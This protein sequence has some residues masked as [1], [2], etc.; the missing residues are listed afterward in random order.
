MT[1]EF[2]T[3]IFS[4]ICGQ[5]NCFII[6]GAA[7][8]VCQRCLGLYVGAALT[9]VWL[10]LSGRWRRGLPTLG[11]ILLHIGPIVVAGLGG[12]H[13][14]GAGATWRLMCGLWTGHMITWWLVGGAVA[15]WRGS[16]RDSARPSRDRMITVHALAALLVL[17]G[18]SVWFE[19][20]SALGGHFWA[21]MPILG[22]ICLAASAAGGL[23]SVVFWAA[24]NI[25]GA[26]P[27]RSEVSERVV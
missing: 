14:M 10:A 7:L 21:F 18:I 9:A 25:G 6:D 20:L 26:M 17:A 4:H 2:L 11:V 15:L 16:M 13:V 12:T 23:L 5:G 19:R 27:P 1:V 8:P 22:A 24:R 3:G